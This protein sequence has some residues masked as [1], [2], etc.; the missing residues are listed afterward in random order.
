MAIVIVASVVGEFAV[1]KLKLPLLASTFPVPFEFPEFRPEE[2]LCPLL[3]PEMV[4]P[5]TSLECLES[6]RVIFFCPELLTQLLPLCLFWSP[7]M[8]AATMWVPADA[9]VLCGHGGNSSRLVRGP[10][11]PGQQTHWF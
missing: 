1:T 2:L 10:G 8:A 9:T 11:A 4:F 5:M 6:A 7:S 3:E